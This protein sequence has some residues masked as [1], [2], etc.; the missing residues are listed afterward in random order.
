MLQGPK[1]TAVAVA[2]GVNRTAG[3]ALTL[4]IEQGRHHKQ[5]LVLK[6]V[7][8]Q[9]SRESGSLS[10]PLPPTAAVVQVERYFP[11][12]SSAVLCTEAHGRGK[13]RSRP[14]SHQHQMRHRLLCVCAVGRYSSFKL[15][16]RRARSMLLLLAGSG[17]YMGYIMYF[18]LWGAG[19]G[20]IGR[21]GTGKEVCRS[22]HISQPR[23]CIHK[24]AR[25]VSTRRR[26]R[27][28]FAEMISV[29]CFDGILNLI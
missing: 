11:M 21:G 27:S 3:C 14:R 25:S 24:R 16:A 28:V 7:G 26:G 4:L 13:Q 12:T 5:T 2:M 10:L 9:H 18:G 1:A 22:V 6:F 23:L 29:F 15:D 19:C 8:E 17:Q 20:G